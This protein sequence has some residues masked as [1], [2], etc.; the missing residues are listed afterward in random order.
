MPLFTLSESEKSRFILVTL[1]FMCVTSS[2]L[3][4]RTVADTLFLAHYGHEY[5]A[6]MYVG[7]ALVVSCVAF[8]YSSLIGRLSIVKLIAVSIV[9]LI[10]LLI[11][12]Q[13]SLMTGWNGVRIGAYF[14]GD[15]VV[16]VP[17]MLFWSFAVLLFDPRQAKRLFGF[18]GAGGTLSCIVAGFVIKPIALTFGTHTLIYGIIALLIGFLAIVRHVSKH[19]PTRF[20]QTQPSTTKTTQIQQYLQHIKTPQIRHLIMFV[21]VA[22]VVLA[23]VDYQFKAGARIHYA[24]DELAGFFGNFY[25]Y[26]SIVA[27]LIQLFLVHRILQKGGIKLGLA[28]LPLGIFVG[29]MGII[30]TAEFS[31]IIGTKVLVQIFLFTIDIAA[32]QMLYMGIPVASRNQARAF[33]DGITKPIAIATAGVGLVALAHVV[34]LHLLALA[35]AI[36]S[37]L[38]LFLV[39]TNNKAYIAALINSLGSKKL[40]LSA[41]TSQFQDSTIADYVCDALKTAKDEEIVYLL[42]IANEITDRDWTPEYRQLIHKNSPEIKILALEHLQHFGDKTDLESITNLLEHNDPR[43]RRETIRCLSTLGHKDTLNSIEPFLQ[44]PTPMVQAAAIASLVNQGDLDQLIDA[45]IRLRDLINSPEQQ[46]RVAS[47]QALADITD[48]VL[49][50]SLAELLKDTDT[51][52]QKAALDACRAHPDI[53]LVSEIIPLLA[54]PEIGVIAADVLA[55]F[56]TLAIP[57]LIEKLSTQSDKTTFTG[58]HR[59]PPILAQI[60]DPSVLP[61]LLQSGD[62]FNSQL[63]N[64]SLQA[65]ASL[66]KQTPN[67]TPFV[68]DAYAKIQEEISLSKAKKIQIEHIQSSPGISLLADALRENCLLHLKNAFALIDALLPQ[69]DA[70]AILE[71]LLR[72]TPPDNNALEVLDNTLPKQIRSDV[73]A[74]FENIQMQEHTHHPLNFETFLSPK[75]DIWV[76]CGALLAAERNAHDIAEPILKTG[77]THP[78]PT[79]RETTLFVLHQQNNPSLLKEQCEILQHDSDPIVQ[80]LACS[81]LTPKTSKINPHS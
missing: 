34:P 21:F 73:I 70:L 12:L 72:T 41:E 33:A 8:V 64:Q 49:H 16:H 7:T 80:Q 13:V 69:I 45:G 65:F 58:T 24:S 2:A 51:A 28:L 27:L 57:Q 63:R 29:S 11:L 54:D 32:V 22:N 81:Y 23:L 55:E 68:K 71:T 30:W 42:S 26:T 14:L 3:I 67:T 61:V 31:W 15:L 37:L 19:D 35:G 10:T 75:E 9:F 40:D 66:L 74:F 46:D 39:H 1:A 53:Q 5:L 79:V 76:I 44:D 60:G 48:S 78:H 47:A 36:L 4:G 17:M 62:S 59:I 6:Q 18:I 38:W 50:R 43:V 20:Q 25:A 52:V 77:L 56:G